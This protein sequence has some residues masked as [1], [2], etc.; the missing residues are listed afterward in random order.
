MHSE[1]S[2]STAVLMLNHSFQWAAYDKTVQNYVNKIFNAFLDILLQI[3]GYMEDYGGNCYLGMG[4]CV[5][6]LAGHRCGCL[7][8]HLGIQVCDIQGHA[9]HCRNDVLRC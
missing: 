9:S 8:V 5:G 1:I 7:L 3:V 2:I 4:Y 6:M